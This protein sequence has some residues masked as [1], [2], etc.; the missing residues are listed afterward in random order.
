MRGGH[1]QGRGSPSTTFTRP[2]RASTS[3]AQSDADSMS[4]ARAA[5]QHV[6]AERL[7]RLRRDETVPGTV[8]ATTSRSTRLI[9]SATGSAGTTPSQPSPRARARA[10]S[11]P[12]ATEAAPRR[13]RAR[14]QRR[15]G[16]RPW[17][18]ERTPREWRRPSLPGI[19]CRRRAPRRGESRALPSPPGRR[20]RSRPPSRSA[21]AV[22]GSRRAAVGRPG[23]RTPSACRPP[24]DLRC[25]QQRGPPTWSCQRRLAGSARRW[26]R[27]W[28][29][30]GACRSCS[31]P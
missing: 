3:D 5:P 10:R 6:G 4:P 1:L 13:A 27:P 31:I 21:P 29:S 14:P 25:Q 30:C 28:P 2:P 11:P 23:A 16:H 12:S 8:S 17:Q 9:V 20:R 24:D 19:P 7:R 15:R 26:L 22:R 18:G